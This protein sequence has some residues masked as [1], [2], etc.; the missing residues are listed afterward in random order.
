MGTTYQLVNITKKEII[1]FT[2]IGAYKALE[3]AGNPASSAIT[4]W[5]LLTH[6]GD[7]IT[8]VSMAVEIQPLQTGSTRD[9]DD[10]TEVTDKV[11]EEL[12]QNKILL[13]EG[14]V[15]FFD[16]EP[17]IYNRKLRNIWM[18]HQLVKLISSVSKCDRLPGALGSS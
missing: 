14:K 10:F 18:E 7:Q 8:F 5:Y 17:Q 6:L 11:V 12:I 13:D 2:H 9:V 3:L 1:W 15:F 16:D 4:T